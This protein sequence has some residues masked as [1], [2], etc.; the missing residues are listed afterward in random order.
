MNIGFLC[1]ELPPAPIGGIGTFIAELAN[2]LNVAGHGVHIVSLDFSASVSSC[3]DV[4]TYLTIHRVAAGRG[5]FHG[6][7]NRFKLFSKVRMIFAG[8]H[9]VEQT[10]NE[11]AFE[12]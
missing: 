2:G 8:L 12:A 1:N 11:T 5:R 3:E 9:H 4:S 6:Y 10:A 7:L